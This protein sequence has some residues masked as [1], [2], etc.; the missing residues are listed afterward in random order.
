MRMVSGSAWLT[1][2]IVV[3]V[4]IAAA[5]ATV[6]PKP[7][8]PRVELES[9]RITTLRAPDARFVVTLAVENPNALDLALD[10][11]DATLVV[12]GERVVAGSLA[13]PVVLAANGWTRVQIDTRM[14]LEAALIALDRFARLPKVRYE[15]A[16]TAVVEGGIV[17]P[18]A[19]SG[20]VSPAD[21][22][23]PTP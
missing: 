3:A 20:V 15:I 13:A 1:T 6:Q 4:F 7:L 11:L 8:P 9:V 14:R 12:E 10:A 21:L 16:G 23:A 5:C 17:L 22:I 2:R 18:F 19:R